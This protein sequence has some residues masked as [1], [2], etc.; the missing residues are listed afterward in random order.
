[1]TM[2]DA[3]KKELEDLKS[4]DLLRKLRQV[5]YL[6]GMCARVDGKECVVFCSN[7]YLGFSRDPRVKGAAAQAAEEYGAGSGASRLVCGDLPIHRRLEERI[8]RFKGLAAAAVLPTGFQANLGVITSLVGEKD[9]VICDRLNHASIV[10]ACRLSGA[11]LLVYA[12]CDLGELEKCLGR[13]DG[14]RRRLIVTDS[15][16]SMDGDLAP[17]AGI[18]RLAERYAAMVMVDEAHAT[19][20]YGEQGQGLAHELGLSKKI[21]VH[22]GTLSKAIGSQGGYVAGDQD[23]IKYIHNKARSF[24]YTTALAP[25]ACGA[26]LKSLE[27]MEGEEGVREKLLSNISRLRRGLAEFCVGED[28]SPIL[29]V[30]IG[31]EQD[32]VQASASLLAAGYFVP[33]IRPPTVPKGTSRLRITVSAL[34]TDEEID[35]LV[36]SLTS[37]VKTSKVKRHQAGNMHKR[38]MSA[39]AVAK[40][41]ATSNEQRATGVFITATDTEVGKTI[42]TCALAVAL[43]EK[44]MDVGVMKPVSSGG[45]PGEDALALKKYSGVDDPIETINP[46]A[47]Q[48]PLAPLV[49]AEKEG[50]TV[51][52]AA[53]MKAREVLEKRHDLLLVEGVGG[54]LVPLA[55]EHTVLDMM[56]SFGYPVLLISRAGLGAVNHTLMSLEL[57]RAKGLEV[58]GVVMNGFRDDEAEVDNPRMI[59]EFGKIKVLVRVPFFK[60][61]D[62]VAQ[63][64]GCLE[65]VVDSFKL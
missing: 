10:D 21:D 39:V 30:I 38:R 61:G 1:M 34:H 33:A 22:M 7:D 55:P 53:I 26:A 54:L 18:C 52:R 50:R 48:R 57:L 40:A 14:F 36:E 31:S 20:V 64:A 2:L 56:S 51:T 9:V 5:E 41:E 12:H 47:F 60:E 15:V 63:A 4:A 24:I 46:C 8:A 43:K 19:G 23:L 6:A 25:A 11:K 32:A 58:L 17:L 62:V 29:P 16:F 42:I 28:G 3:I 65:R 59:E 27:L 49:A 13:G 45:V 35:G 44:G 37:N